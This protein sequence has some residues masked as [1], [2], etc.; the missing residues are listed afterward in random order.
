MMRYLEDDF[1]LDYKLPTE[2]LLDVEQLWKVFGPGRAESA[3]QLAEGGASR[4]EI[5]EG[6]GQLPK[7]EGDLF[8]TAAGDR[9]LY[10]IPTAE[11]PLTILHRDEILAVGGSRPALESFKAFRG[12]PPSVDA[13]LRHSGMILA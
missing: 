3:I 11:V 8:K 6:T 5:L 7:F 13:L 10:L 9:D 2:F 4:A 1:S 12:R